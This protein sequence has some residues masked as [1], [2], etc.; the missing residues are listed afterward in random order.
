MTAQ[1]REA[2]QRKLTILRRKVRAAV[3]EH[4]RRAAREVVPAYAG[5][6]S[7]SAL[8]RAMDVERSLLTLCLSVHRNRPSRNM[9]RKLEAHLGLPRGGMDLVLALIE[10][11]PIGTD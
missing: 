7:I 3:K 8:A 2:Q 9:R 5:E 11:V 10:E 6:P 4:G 1:E